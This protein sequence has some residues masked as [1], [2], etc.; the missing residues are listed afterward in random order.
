MPCGYLYKRKYPVGAHAPPQLHHQCGAAVERTACSGPVWL[1]LLTAAYV[2]LCTA[3]IAGTSQEAFV[4]A[5][6]PGEDPL[7]AV[8]QW[9]FSALCPGGIDTTHGCG[10]CIQLYG[11]PD[12]GSGCGFSCQAAT[13]RIRGLRAGSVGVRNDTAVELFQGM[14]A[15]RVNLAWDL[16]PTRAITLSVYEPWT[17]DGRGAV[18]RV[19]LLHDDE[20]VLRWSDADTTRTCGYR[21]CGYRVECSAGNAMAGRA[22]PHTRAVSCCALACLGASSHLRAPPPRSPLHSVRW[23]TRDRPVAVV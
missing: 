17:I 18:R 3:T 1:G 19:E 6:S 12:A 16:D 8:Q 23:V 10:G 4:P 14:S 2:A 5:V 9:A 11:P 22:L 13:I 7:P 21:V 15:V 20:R